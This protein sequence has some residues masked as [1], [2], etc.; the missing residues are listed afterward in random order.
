MWEEMFWIS[1]ATSC[2]QANPHT[3]DHSRLTQAASNEVSNTVKEIHKATTG[4][5]GT[6]MKTKE[7]VRTTSVQETRSVMQA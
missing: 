2:S 7:T 4:S 3:T 1:A 6:R 5:D